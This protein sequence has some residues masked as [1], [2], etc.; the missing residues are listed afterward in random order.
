MEPL[1][2]TGIAVYALN[3]DIAQKLLGPTIEYIG[4]EGKNLVERCNIN[5]NEIFTKAAEKAPHKLESQGQVSPRI[6]RTLLNEAAFCSNNIVQEYYAGILTASKTENQED[7][8][9]IMFMNIV[10]NLTIQQI[11]MHQ[12][13]FMSTSKVFNTTEYRAESNHGIFIPS[14]LFITNENKEYWVEHA[15]EG[16]VRQ[17]LIDINYSANKTIAELKSYNQAITEEGFIIKPLTTGEE[18]FMWSLG[19]EELTFAE[20]LDS[21]ELENEDFEGLLRITEDIILKKY[22]E[23][24]EHLNPVPIYM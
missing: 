13:I 10:T 24:T 18:L 12:L 3:T 16:L 21:V 2:T 4:N 1:I 8:R 20:Y 14:S 9:G 11:K 17:R 6:L 5:L 22:Q 15:L 19:K 23:A 7:D